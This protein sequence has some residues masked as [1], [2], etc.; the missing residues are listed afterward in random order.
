[1]LNIST[2]DT[3][4]FKPKKDITF[5]I[6]PFTIGLIFYAVDIDK[7]AVTSNINNL[8]NRDKISLV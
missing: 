8:Y 1:L 7:F 4:E 2:E 6:D 3:A 5:I